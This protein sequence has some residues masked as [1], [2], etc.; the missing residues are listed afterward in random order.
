V[1]YVKFGAVRPSPTAEQDFDQLLA[2]CEELAAEKG[3]AR[4]VAGVNTARHEAYRQ[5]LKRSFC[6]DLQG[7]AMQ[8]DNATG[9]NRQGVY[10]IDDWRQCKQKRSASLVNFY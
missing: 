6:T 3:L 10:L 1:C 8:R 9:Y 7:V 4:L 5:M 2:A